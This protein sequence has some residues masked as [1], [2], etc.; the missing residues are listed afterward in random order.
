MRAQTPKDPAMTEPKNRTH[1]DAQP[2]TGPDL[3]ISME[4]DFFQAFE[5]AKTELA[6]TIP[7]TGETETISVPIPAGAVSGGRLRL[8]GHGDYGTNDGERGDL[9]IETVV[10]DEPPYR[11]DGADVLLDWEVD[12]ELARQGGNIEVPAPNGKTLRVSIPAGS[13]SGT[14]LRV[15]GYGAPDLRRESRPGDLYIVLNFARGRKSV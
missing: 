2:I 6:I 11:R 4:V 13:T 9:I 5:G 12:D 10:L 1:D 7:F 3:H 8:K 14:R 15:P